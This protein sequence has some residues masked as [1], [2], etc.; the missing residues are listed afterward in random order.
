MDKWLQ[1]YPDQWGYLASAR[2]L[3]AD[4]LEPV[5]S[6]ATG[7][8]H[9]LDVRFIPDEDEAEPWRRT[10]RVPK[11]LPAPLPTALTVTLANQLYFEK[12]QLT[13]P[14]I[15]RLIRLAT[16]QNPEFYRAQA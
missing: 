9:P 3:A 15:N 10:T 5:I 1:P 2:T 13:Q 14:L 4:S 12:A 8:G 6:S 7:G 16:F 11:H